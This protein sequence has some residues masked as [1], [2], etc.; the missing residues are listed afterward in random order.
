MQK[1][2]IGR[3]VTFTDV[4]GN[5]HSATI[6]KVWTDVTVNL[7]ILKDNGSGASPFAMTSVPLAQDGTPVLNRW[8]WPERV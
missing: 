1:P 6:T 7:W 8:S 2:T 3:Q 5:S 4:E